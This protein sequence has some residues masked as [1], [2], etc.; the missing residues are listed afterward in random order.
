[1]SNFTALN[2][3]QLARVSEFTYSTL[4]FVPI[5]FVIERK[6]SAAR[7]VTLGRSRCVRIWLRREIPLV[8]SCV[9][10]VGRCSSLDQLLCAWGH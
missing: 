9:L 3:L 6:S 2:V 5:V 1:M 8:V 10:K 4:R 7:H